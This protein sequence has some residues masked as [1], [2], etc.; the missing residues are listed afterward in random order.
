[1]LSARLQATSRQRG[2][3]TFS[4]WKRTSCMLDAVSSS[5]LTFCL[6]PSLTRPSCLHISLSLSLH[7][8]MDCPMLSFSLLFSSLSLS[9]CPRSIFPS[10]SALSPLLSRSHLDCPLKAFNFLEAQCSRTYIIFTHDWRLSSHS[11]KTKQKHDYVRA[12]NI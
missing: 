2:N 5:S 1:M 11:E 12:C 9:L 4:G 8:P 6:P 7:R 3:L 10:Y